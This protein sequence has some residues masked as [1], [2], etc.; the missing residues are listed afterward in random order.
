MRPSCRIQALLSRQD[1][2]SHEI[3]LAS[4]VSRA[5]VVTSFSDCSHFPDAFWKLVIVRKT[6]T[7]IDDRKPVTMRRLNI[8][9]QRVV[10]S[11][12]FAQFN[13][14]SEAMFRNVLTRS[15]GPFYLT[16]SKKDEKQK[17]SEFRLRRF[18]EMRSQR[19]SARLCPYVDNPARGNLYRASL[20]G[21]IHT[22]SL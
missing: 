15:A 21:D 18:L 14:T 4:P 20:P 1:V 11:S 5:S 8:F 7:E 22:C 19:P 9:P 10:R 3:L 13:L 2:A 17:T 12:L 16:T 6:K